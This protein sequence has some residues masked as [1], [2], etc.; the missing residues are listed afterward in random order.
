MY[1]EHLS[2]S[3]ESLHVSLQQL[4]AFERAVLTF[5]FWSDRRLTDEA[6]WDFYRAMR[7][8]T[9]EKCA[10]LPASVSLIYSMEDARPLARRTEERLDILWRDGVRILTPLWRGVT[11]LGGSYDTD[12]PLS[13]LG[14]EVVRAAMER[15]FLLDLS[16]ASRESAHEILALADASGVPVCAS[17]SDFYSVC[18]HPRNLTDEEALGIARRGGI[19]GLSFV[20]SHLGGDESIHALL[21]HIRH[22]LSL[23]LAKHMA[24][25]SD[26][27]G[28]DRLPRGMSHGVTDLPA[29]AQGFR[30]AGLPEGL[31]EDLFYKNAERSLTHLLD[32]KSNFGYDK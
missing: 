24:L 8:D 6:A 13:P 14:V 32:R 3:D 17:H 22:G 18:P 20:P 27:D 26:Y 31:L 11:S 1:T 29:L 10:A 12:R 16:H 23:G 2:F 15:G 21:R 7:R 19:I 30:Q 25:G 9:A 4:A 5:A 28:T